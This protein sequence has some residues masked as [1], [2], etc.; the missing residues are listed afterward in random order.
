M[1]VIVPTIT[2]SDP[3]EY[4]RQMEQIAG[5]AERVHID[6]MDG[7]FAPTKSPDFES[8]WWLKTM[9]ADFH[10][11]YKSPGNYLNEIIRLA[12]S[13]VIIHAEAD[14]DFLA[15]AN[16]LHTAKIKVGVALLPETEVAKINPSLPV[17]DHALIFGGNLG[18]QGGQADLDQLVKVK[19]LKNLKPELEIGWDGGV[20]ETNIGRIASAG[21]DV[22]NVGSYIQKSANPDAAYAKL[23]E[24]I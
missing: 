13:L 9:A 20:D 21:V 1:P 6:F 15:L 12:P 19:D 18:Y 5:F 14:G 2:A 8:A 17:I 7:I 22:L 11:M 10:V 4:R 3:H 23:K 16:H 24:Q